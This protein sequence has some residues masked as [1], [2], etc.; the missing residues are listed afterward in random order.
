[1][2]GRE[3]YWNIGYP[4]FGS[5]VSVAAGLVLAMAAYALWRR[6][7]I[8]RLGAPVD[9]L[10]P[11]GDRIK[12]FGGYLLNDVLLHRKLIRH[13]HYPG[14]MHLLIFWGFLILLVATVLIGLEFYLGRYVGW[15]LPTVRY[16]AQTGLVWDVG[17]VL[18]TVGLLMAAYRRY[19]IRPSR[20]PTKFN[21]GVVLGLLLLLIITGYLV[22]GMRI[23]ATEL[24][25]SSVLYNPGESG[26]SP[27]GWVVAKAMIRL[28][29]TP[30]AMETI[31][32]ILWWVHAAVFL[33]GF[34]YMA[35]RFGRLAHI[36]ISP[37]HI[38][39]RTRELPV[40]AE[41]A[42]GLGVKKIA[43]LPDMTWPI[44]RT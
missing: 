10:V 44:C 1:M 16:S 5:L 13:E 12:M 41:S 38:F 39:L 28:G 29:V 26:W 20:I 22:E 2:V 43:D 3:E 37:L 6:V 27:V 21:A 18:A 36:A 9:D 19:V 33:G 30:A 24:N 40:P 7:R 14:V 35:V 11:W 25:G 31:H 8:W 32:V 42:D 15:T 17:G 23:G 34:G 4:L